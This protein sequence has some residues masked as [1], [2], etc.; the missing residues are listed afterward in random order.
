LEKKKGVVLRG[1]KEKEEGTKLFV[2]FLGLISLPG[3]GN[4]DTLMHREGKK[5]NGLGKFSYK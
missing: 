1:E 4:N 2:F 5:E 3:K